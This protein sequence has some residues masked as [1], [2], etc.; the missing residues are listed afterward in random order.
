ML[1]ALTS[2]PVE[3]EAALELSSTDGEVADS[4]LALSLSQPA[5]KEGNRYQSL[6]QLDGFDSLP[7]GEYS[8][9][10]RFQAPEGIEVEPSAVALQ[11]TIPTPEVGLALAKHPPARDVSG[12][13]LVCRRDA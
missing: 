9:R 3:L 6:L 4:P 5:Y 10:I 8:G 2:L 7:P 1:T 12:A 11:F 13:C